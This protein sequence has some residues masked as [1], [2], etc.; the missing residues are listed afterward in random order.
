LDIR[1]TLSHF[2]TNCYDVMKYLVDTNVLSTVATNR[3]EIVAHRFRSM[4]RQDIA[5]CDVVLH[6][7][8]SGL[9]ANPAI[10]DKLGVIYDA[11]FDSLTILPTDQAVW[12]RAAS[13]RAN[14]KLRDKPI[15]PYDLLIAAIAAQHNLILVT[16]N[17]REFDNV[18][19]IQ[20]EDWSAPPIASR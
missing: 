8:S 17:K 19:G 13:I 14:L 7:V 4:R 9:A 2:V 1:R 20:V 15:G 16:S 18:E 6:E 11:L 12:L 10:A 3:V 5:T